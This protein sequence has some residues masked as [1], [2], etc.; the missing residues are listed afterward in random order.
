VPA[1]AW[2]VIGVLLASAPVAAQ[3]PHRAVPDYDA[4]EEPEADAEDALLW[5]PR[6][7]TGPLY[8]VS[9]YLIRRPLIDLGHYLEEHR[10][11]QDVMD[12]LTFG[13]NDSIQI[14]PTLFADFGFLPSVGFTGHWNDFLGSG[15]RLSA[16]LTTFGPD[17]IS[18]RGALSVNVGN[19]VSV[20]AT[21]GYLRRPDMLLGGELLHPPL[22]TNARY[23][24]ERSN[25]EVGYVLRYARSSI[26]G[27]LLM[28]SAS[29][30]DTTYGSD[31]SIVT[32]ARQTGSTLPLGFAHGYVIGILHVHAALDTRRPLGMPAGGVRIGGFGDLARSFTGLEDSRWFR[33]GGEA[34]LATDALGSRRVLSLGLDASAILPIGQSQIPFDQSIDIGGLGPM[35]GFLPGQVRGTTAIALTVAYEWPIWVFLH[36]RIYAAVGNAFARDFEGF[37]LDR[38]RLSVGV[39][40]HPTDITDQPFEA[41]FGIG[42]EAFGDGTQIAS[43]R[44]FFG[45]RRD[46]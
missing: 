26:G 24:I 7:L 35:P 18:A 30:G 1:H 37:A 33:I 13:P 23:S 46:L 25:A 8:I 31:P 44:A 21:G 9:E 15:N 36:A 12:F 27:S 20:Y 22:T 43:V 5:I 41:G 39:G 45:L 11:I 40:L 3:T 2:V 34:L 42:T 19:H 29:F 14:V 10:T 38:L 28:Q 4:R 16:Q 17:W 6:I 32:L